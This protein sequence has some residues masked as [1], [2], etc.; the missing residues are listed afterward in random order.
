MRVRWRSKIPVLLCAV[1]ACA[2]AQEF[3]QI[4]T[5]NFLPAVRDQIERAAREFK[6]HP[7]DAKAA[8]TLGMTLHAYEQYEAATRAY[9]RAHQLDPGAF[10]WIY[11]GAVLAMQ[12]GDFDGAAK[13]FRAALQIRPGD[14]VAQ[15]RLGQSLTANGNWGEAGSLYRRILEAHPDNPQA[16]YGRGRV[17]AAS[18]DREAAARSYAKACELF[19]LYGAAHFALA[20]E[21]RKLGRRAE[22]DEHSA[23]YLKD[24][25]AEPPLH[26]ALLQRTRELNQGVQTHLQRGAEFE[27]QGKLQDAIREHEAALAID[28]EN[29]QI[30]INLIS[31]YGRAGDAGKA[32]GHFEL[33]TR[34][35]PGRPDAWYNYG[36]LM[37]QQKAYREAEQA[38]RRAVEI[39]PYYAEAHN[40]LGAVYQMQAR[41][42][43]A[44]REFRDAIAN[45]PDYP[46]ARFQLARILVSEQKYDEAIQQL[47]KALTPEDDQTPRYIYALAATYARAGNREQALSYY[48]RA[49]D[50]A[51]ARGQSQLLD[52]IDRDL[53]MLSGAR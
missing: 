19:P 32:R 15:L 31:L 2:G 41:L 20:G 4:D 3:P 26:D 17:E 16:W 6:T 33:A 52:S 51:A 42:G 43:D 23:A 9:A 10:E 39:N 11:L 45:K 1:C 8:G 24:P 48:T 47:Q 49:R 44:A 7:G 38:F 13:S 29:V 36:V 40:N 5:A 28:P 22:A 12:E 21:L 14:M 30:H 25:S 53:K 18:A 37:F 34:L 46:L 35:N 27:K 50:A